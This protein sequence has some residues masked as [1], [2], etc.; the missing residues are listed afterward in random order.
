MTILVV[1]VVSASGFFVI[2]SISVFVYWYKANF[3]NRVSMTTTSLCTVKFG[4][5]ELGYNETSVITNIFSIPDLL[6]CIKSNLL[7]KNK[8]IRNTFRRYRGVPY[9]RGLLY[10]FEVI[11]TKLY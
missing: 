10:T 3:F 1:A 5:I 8:A 9:N 2:V 6:K 11:S 4:F 7:Y